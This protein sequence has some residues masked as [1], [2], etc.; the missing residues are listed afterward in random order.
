MYEQ[1][2]FPRLVE[3][4]LRDALSD[5]P[6]VL[7]HG[8]RQCGKT[9]L[10][11]LTCAPHQLDSGARL[12]RST[13]NTSSSERSSQLDEYSYFTFDDNALREA[14]QADP[15]G[16]VYDLP[17]RVIL[18]EIQRVPE[19]FDVIKIVVDRERTAGRFLLTGSTNVLLLP[20]LSR[21]L[22]GRLQIISLHPLAQYEIARKRQSHV[23]KTRFLQSLFNDGFRTNAT[24]RLGRDLIQKVVAGG[25]P[26][27]LARTT[28]IRQADWYRNYVDTLVQRDV[29]Q[30]T[31]I[32]SLDV[33][34]R[35][36]AAAASQ[37]ARVF[38]I[39]QLASPFN[40]SNPTIAHYVTLLEQ[41]YLTER[42]PSWHSN[43]LKRLVKVPKLHIIDTGLAAALLR[44]GPEQLDL[45]RK[46]FGQLLETFVFQ[47][48]KRQA[49]AYD[50]PINFY[51]FRDRDGVEVDIV[52]ERGYRAIAG[53]EVK[54]AA[55]VKA[56][57]FRGLKKLAKA[58]GDQFL[59]GLVLY[60]GENTIPFGNKL[61]CVPIRCLWE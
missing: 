6:V 38:N 61:Y 28:S 21:S 11:Q 14:A 36:L 44:V 20:Q 55:T 45:D 56:E 34:P 60:D 37:T 47:E 15:I 10:A 41:I 40:L 35:L 7:I 3:R 42:L 1:A 29:R 27:A 57:D 49:S 48:L 31:Q 52:L 22:A 24:K 50:E 18:D 39:S 26:P 16:F 13:K 12:E 53:I 23:S 51:H 2:F 25:F 59:F 54:A 58:S 43:S 4:R 5:S 33:L 32:Q 17:D 9:T 46:L 19:L 8:P 30:A